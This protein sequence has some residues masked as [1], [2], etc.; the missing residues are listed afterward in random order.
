MLLSVAALVPLGRAG[1]SARA[2]QRLLTPALVYPRATRPLVKTSASTAACHDAV[3]PELA[4]L[5]G[6]V[7]VIKPLGW[8]SADAVAKVKSVFQRFYKAQ[9]APSRDVRKLKVGHGG[10]LDPGATG[11]LVIGVGDGCKAMHAMLAGEKCY[12]TVGVLGTATDT[13]DSTGSVVST[14]ACEHVSSEM[15]RAS[16]TAFRGNIMQ[17][18]PAFSALK[19]GGEKLYEKARR[20]E[21]VEHLLEPRAVTVFSLEMSG[22]GGPADAPALFL[23]PPMPTVGASGLTRDGDWE[24]AHCGGHNFARRTVCFKCGAAQPVI[25]SGSAASS[26]LDD[27]PAPLDARAF[28]LEMRVSGGFYVRSLVRDVGVACGSVAHMTSLCR[29]QQGSFHLDR[30][31]P[32]ADWTPQRLCAAMTPPSPPPHSEG[33]AARP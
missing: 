29:T 14:A 3:M 11:V 31:L 5:H 22:F 30:A 28:G 7:P 12:T 10:T 18:P 8:S 1:E 32:E 33:P 15:L 24:C 26:R 21:N 2:T 23:G 9:G 17:T 19:R 25:T 20:G 6:V 13:L 4:A 16:L 27:A